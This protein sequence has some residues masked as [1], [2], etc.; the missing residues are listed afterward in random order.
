[1]KLWAMMSLEKAEAAKLSVN[2]DSAKHFPVDLFYCTSLTL[3]LSRTKADC[4]KHILAGQ[5]LESTWISLGL[6]HTV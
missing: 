6:T 5:I 3:A 4:W 1:M 2:P